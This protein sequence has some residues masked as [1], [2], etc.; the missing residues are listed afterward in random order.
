MPEGR[1]GFQVLPH[2]FDKCVDISIA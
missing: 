1:S 2:P